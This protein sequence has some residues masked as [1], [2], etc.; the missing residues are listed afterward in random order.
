MPKLGPLTAQQD[1][2]WYALDGLLLPLYV[3]R[4]LTEADFGLSITN[5]RADGVW[6]TGEAGHGLRIYVLD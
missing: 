3:S 2:S 1:G 5:I 4:I 6:S